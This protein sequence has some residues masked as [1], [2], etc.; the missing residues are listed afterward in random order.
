VEGSK[1]LKKCS[2]NRTHGQGQERHTAKVREKKTFGGARSEKDVILTRE[3][4][5]KRLLRIASKE[6]GKRKK[7]SGRQKPGKENNVLQG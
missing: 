3:P 4:E 7:K 6:K 5:K 1:K 2:R